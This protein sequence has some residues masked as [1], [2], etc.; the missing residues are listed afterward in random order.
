MNSSDQLEEVRISD[1]TLLYV[2]LY[3]LNVAVYFILTS[4]RGVYRCI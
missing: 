3:V 4:S 1:E 2:L